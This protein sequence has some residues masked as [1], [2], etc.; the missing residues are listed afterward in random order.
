M[1]PSL[2]VTAVD[3]LFIT[4]IVAAYLIRRPYTRMIERTTVFKEIESL[5]LPAQSKGAHAIVCGGSW[6]GILSA[7]VLLDH[8]EKVTI[9]ESD[10]FDLFDDEPLRKNIAQSK[11]NHIMMTLGYN[12]TRKLFPGIREYWEY[13][14][15]IHTTLLSGVNY[16]YGRPTPRVTVS[17]SET[18]L[19]SRPLMESGVRK[20]LLS[21]YQGTGRLEF[22]MKAVVK[23]LVV[24]KTES[25]TKVVG[26]RF[27]NGQ[28][29][30]EKELRADFVVD[31][32]GR[33]QKGVKWLESLDIVV[34]C[35]SYDPLVVYHA[36]SYATPMRPEVTSLGDLTY[37]S[38]LP[39]HEWFSSA[40]PGKTHNTFFF[41]PGLNGTYTISCRSGGTRKVKP[42]K[43]EDSL[44]EFLQK[45]AILQMVQVRAGGPP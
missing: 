32:T 31:A 23:G 34:P 44:N 1:F 33:S 2:P 11:H 41:S 7:R 24:D 37:K 14:G 40:W 30:I 10:D 18:I 28:E 17:T 19:A 39:W 29:K 26:V 13:R 20:K 36:A 9:L 22:K 35:E 27:L 12:I 45:V 6:A 42:V 21:L 43:D 38:S 16:F 15:G 8:F 3:T 4:A 5:G 25:R